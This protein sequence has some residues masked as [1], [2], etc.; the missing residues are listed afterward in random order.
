MATRDEPYH[1]I[2]VESYVL[3]DKSGRNGPVLIRPVKGGAFPPHLQVECSK[4]L[5]DT[6]RYGVGS[7]FRIKAKLTERRRG[8]DYLFSFHGWAVYEVHVVPPD[9]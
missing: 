5:S 2:E 3:R 4:T 7:R 1:W 8:G 9:Q 6:S